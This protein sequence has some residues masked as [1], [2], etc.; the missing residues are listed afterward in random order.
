MIMP[1][2]LRKLYLEEK[3]IITGTVLKAYCRA[4]HLDYDATIRYLLRNNYLRRI[5]RGIFYLPSIE[6]RKLK[7][8]GLTPLNAVAE[9]LKIKS[10]NNWY[11]GLETAMKLNNL[12]HEFFTT[13]TVIS[14]TLFRAKFVTILGRPI[15]FV[16]VKKSLFGFGVIATPVNFSDPEKTL[17][18][19]VYL[20][21][22]EGLADK[23]I[24]V[25]LSDL[26]DKCSY[27]KLVKYSKNYN[28]VI[29]RLVKK[30]A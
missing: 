13:E 3:K 18:D 23:E 30:W 9:A 4:L 17:L 7:R 26:R 25:K 27:H 29:E 1:L 14:D 8:I 12:T 11:F 15:K 2:L 24:T 20:S 10:V 6:E 5:L 21:R 16:K 22:Y 19:I 28:K